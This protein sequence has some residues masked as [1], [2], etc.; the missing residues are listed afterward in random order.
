M[1]YDCYS[2]E[3]GLCK[4]CFK[5]AIKQK[6]VYTITQERFL[7]H[8][9]EINKRALENIQLGIPLPRLEC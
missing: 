6:G 8:K 4:K 9:N 3:K 7:K 2:K 5:L 1:T